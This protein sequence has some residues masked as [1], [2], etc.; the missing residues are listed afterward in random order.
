LD[1]LGFRKIVEKSR[2]DEVGDL[3]Q[4]LRQAA[5]PDMKVAEEY[6]MSFLTFSD[7]TVRAVPIESESNK[8]H[9]TGILY[10]ELLNLVYCQ[11]R[12]LHDGYF[13]R[14]A[15]T[16]GDICFDEDMVFGPALVNAYALESQFANCPRIVVD[17]VVFA[18]F[19]EEPLLRNKI[20]DVPTER[21]Y[22][23]AIV[24]RDSD[25]IYFV[26]YL[27][28]ILSE[29]DEEGQ[30]FEFLALHKHRVLERAEGF[31]A[32]HKVAAK[33]LWLATYHNDLIRDIGEKQ[34]ADR[35]YDIDDFLIAPNEM[36]LVYEMDW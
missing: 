22:L 33:Y 5:Q 14:G 23:A 15:V 19:D 34:F 4:R 13:L 6:E 17:P 10:F 7:C 30:E 24:K 1:I 20:H 36:P 25:G 27:R 3:L 16:I 28:A 12:L 35:D 11:Y 2:A 31:R 26:D 21:E 32:L 18:A 9:P 29:F 8:K